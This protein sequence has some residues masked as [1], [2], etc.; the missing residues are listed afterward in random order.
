MENLKQEVERSDEEVRNMHAEMK[1]GAVVDS[2]GIDNGEL[3]L[4]QMLEKAEAEVLA[5][6]RNDGGDGNDQTNNDENR[7]D[8]D[9][10]NEISNKSDSIDMTESVL[11]GDER[12]NEDVASSVVLQNEDVAIVTNAPANT[13][14]RN[15]GSNDNNSDTVSIS[16]EEDKSRSGEIADIMVDSSDL[17]RNEIP[18][19]ASAIDTK[20]SAPQPQGESTDE[21]ISTSH[22]IVEETEKSIGGES[23]AKKE[24]EGKGGFWDI[25]MGFMMGDKKESLGTNTKESVRVDG[26]DD[27]AMNTMKHDDHLK[28]PPESSVTTDVSTEGTDGDENRKHADSKHFNIPAISTP[29][30]DKD[31]SHEAAT[32]GVLQDSIVKSISDTKNEAPGSSSAFNNSIDAVVDSTSQT[33]TTSS[34]SS[35]NTLPEG[36]LIDSTADDSSKTLAASEESGEATSPPVSVTNIDG[37]EGGE[38]VNATTLVIVNATMNDS[39]MPLSLDDQYEQKIIAVH[40]PSCIQNMTS[41]TCE[42]EMALISDMKLV[43]DMEKLALGISN[44]L[45]VLPSGKNLSLSIK[46]RDCYDNLRF[47]D[48]QAKMRAKLQ[49]VSPDAASDGPG[50]QDNVFRTLMLRI[51]S[52][53]MNTGIVEMYLSQISDCY[54]AVINDLIAA[55]NASAVAMALMTNARKGLEV[56]DIIKEH[57]VDPKVVQ[58]LAEATTARLHEKNPQFSLFKF[59]SGSDHMYLLFIVGMIFTLFCIFMFGFFLYS[60]MAKRV[61]ELESALTIGTDDDNSDYSVVSSV[62]SRS[63]RK[64]MKSSYHDSSLLGSRG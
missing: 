34:P 17:T 4:E 49:L 1:A 29:E 40:A 27:T 58:I 37:N 48:F 8:N 6:M 43:Q 55:G 64:V 2:V 53:E 24:K 54:R 20:P 33:S 39:A 11:R 19:E 25:D 38:N 62:G 61:K 47:L 45:A 5:E 31:N 63:G 44:Q 22:D 16:V 35:N 60:S 14:L 15:G 41:E 10:V 30:R 3:T 13:T 51:K 26:T 57:L 7:I 52:L 12:K 42:A 50:S 59:L 46:A 23:K 18:T 36:S 9:I 32:N 28:Y 56:S 21:E